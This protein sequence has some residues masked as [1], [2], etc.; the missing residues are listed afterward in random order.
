MD[1]ARFKREMEIRR[2][3]WMAQDLAE[4]REPESEEQAATAID[5]WRDSLEIRDEAVRR[6]RDVLLAY[7]KE[8]QARK[9]GLNG[10][11]MTRICADLLAEMWVWYETTNYGGPVAPANTP[12]DLTH[13]E[14]RF[15]WL[16]R[17][18]KWDE[19]EGRRRSR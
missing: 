17:G 16:M 19:R 13:E 2:L 1:E 5:S 10:H 8:L 14:F 7:H 11:D 18:R 9:L 12:L 15:S 6:C 3:L 4:G